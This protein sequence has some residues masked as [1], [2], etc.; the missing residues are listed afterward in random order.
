MTAMQTPPTFDSQI[1]PPGSAES[2][3][4]RW[5]VILL[6]V[7]LY[8]PT[9]FFLARL[10]RGDPLFGG[11]GLAA[12]LPV[13]GALLWWMHRAGMLRLAVSCTL[14]IIAT[15]VFCFVFVSNGVEGGW[16]GY[17]TMAWQ[18][19]TEWWTLAVVKLNELWAG[20]VVLVIVLSAFLSLFF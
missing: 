12:W 11:L 5:V 18:H 6:M 15:M 20:L 10:L 16:A 14:F 19:V 4:V 13:Y 9:A 8:V 1:P 2:L 3:L 7:V 17:V